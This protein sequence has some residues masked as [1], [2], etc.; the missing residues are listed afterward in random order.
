M[1][2]DS[3]ETPGRTAPSAALMKALVEAS[4][5]GVSLSLMGGRE[6]LQY[7]VVAAT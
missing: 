4:E 3:G 6:N 5:H 1:A 7:W 2:Q